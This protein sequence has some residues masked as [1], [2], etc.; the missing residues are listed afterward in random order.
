MNTSLDPDHQS[1][2][3]LAFCKATADARR[4][5]ILRVLCM[6]SFGVLELCG[7]FNMPQPGLSHHL[8]ILTSANLLSTRRE[9]TS[10]FYRRALISANNPL[11]P[12]ISDLFA[13]LD[14]GQLSQC[15]EKNLQQIHKER[16]E[17]SEQFFAKHAHRLKDNQD[18]IVNF[19]HYTSCVED[20]LHNE[21]IPSSANVIEIGPGQ[22]PLLNLL[23][24]S[25]A[26]IY[27]LDNSRQMLQVAESTLLPKYRKKVHFIFTDLKTY[28]T[29]VDLIVLNMVLHHIASPNRF[30]NSAAELLKPNGRLLI[31]DLCPHD[32]DWTRD[33]CGDLWLGFDPEELD[34]WAR[35]S[36]FDIGQSAYLGL[37]NG[38]QV[39][40]RLFKAA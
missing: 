13:L 28:R 2:Q 30:F 35:E 37:K 1:A 27:A 15:F 8:K 20:I 14:Q 10:I 3:L 7:I 21:Q 12:I 19:D 11:E 23:A 29:K 33:S 38:F 32:Q 36:K 6:E 34:T 9:G 31:I 26:E 5:D 25:F 40:L 18:Y 22:S 24:A 17:K 4:L 39:Q 16:A